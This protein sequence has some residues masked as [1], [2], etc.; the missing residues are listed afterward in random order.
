MTTIDVENPAVSKPYGDSNFPMLSNLLDF[1]LSPYPDGFE[2]AGEGFELTID[3]E[4]QSMDVLT[5]AYARK[6]IK[7]NSTLE[8]G[9]QTVASGIHADWT[10]ESADGEPVTGWDGQAL[11]EENWHLHQQD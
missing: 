1:H 4:V 2:I 7:S 3:G 5:G 6:A 8:F 11:G 9:F 10:I